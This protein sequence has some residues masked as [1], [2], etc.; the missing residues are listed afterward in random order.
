[1]TK[2]QKKN[3]KKLDICENHLFRLKE[4]EKKMSSGDSRSKNDLKPPSSMN[5]KEKEDLE[6]SWSFSR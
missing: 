5:T 6:R 3:K 2:S 1:M 4:K